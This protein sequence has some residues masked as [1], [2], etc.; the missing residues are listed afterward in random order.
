MV[1]TTIF[2]DLDATLYSPTNGLLQNLNHRIDTYM[3]EHLKMPPDQVPFLRDKYFASYGTTLAG[4]R[5]HHRVDADEYQTFV[6]DVDLENYLSPDPALRSFLQSLEQDL[7]IFTNSCFSYARK[8][9]QFLT[10][11]DLFSGIIDSRAVGHN[12]KPANSAYHE[13]LRIAGVQDPSRTILV[14]DRLENLLPAGELGM[15]TVHVHPEKNAH[16]ADLVVRQVH[17][18]ADQIPYLR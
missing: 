14:D 12:P 3:M 6:H 10:V 1:Y 4:L 16:Q 5:K 13:A 2:F 8:V 18:M 7:W 9:L 11:E 17:D 15:F